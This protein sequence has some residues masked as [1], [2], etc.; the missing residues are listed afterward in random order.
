[1]QFKF[2]TTSAILEPGCLKL[3]LFT[4]TGAILLQM[5][6]NGHWSRKSLFSGNNEQVILAQIFKLK[7]KVSWFKG[8]E[9]M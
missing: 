6:S 2:F 1:M 9:E 3:Q 8:H 4:I 7:L 5:F